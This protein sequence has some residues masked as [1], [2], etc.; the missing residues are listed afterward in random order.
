MRGK[1]LPTEAE[2]EYALRLTH[3]GD[4]WPWGGASTPPPGAGNYADST[5]KTKYD[6]WEI[7]EGYD[8]GYVGTAPVCS[9]GRTAAGLCDISGN[10]FE[11]TADWFGENTYAQTQTENPK[12]VSTGSEKVLRGGAWD[13]YPR[14]IRSSDRHKNPP[15]YR[16]NSVGFRC[17]RDATP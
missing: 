13:S 17:V 9:F 3:P 7:F 12:G 2:F 4:V 14:N 10:I 15:V 8:D 16:S 1:R 5:A 6:K 11:W